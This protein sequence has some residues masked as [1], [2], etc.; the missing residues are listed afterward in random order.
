MKRTFRG[1]V[2][3][4]DICA[5]RLVG[6]V[7]IGIVETIVL[8]FA[9]DRSGSVALAHSSHAITNK[10]NYN[11]SSS[12]PC[13]Y[14]ASS[15]SIV[16]VTRGGQQR[17]WHEQRSIELMCQLG[18]ATRLGRKYGTCTITTEMMLPGHARV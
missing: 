11:T 18:C 4:L 10:R 14:S 15:S 5:P 13:I 6:V 9:L 2:H 17:E 16:V 12:L 7:V 8:S 3:V 1:I